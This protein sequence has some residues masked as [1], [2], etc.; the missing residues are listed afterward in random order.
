MKTITIGNLPSKPYMHPADIFKY[1]A[2][3]MNFNEVNFEVQSNGTVSYKFT[4][5]DINVPKEFV[6]SLKIISKNSNT[7][8]ANYRVSQLSVSYIVSKTGNE[9]LVMQERVF[10]RCV[11][12][13][14]DKVTI[15]HINLNNK[16]TIKGAPTFHIYDKGIVWNYTVKK[17][18]RKPKGFPCSK[19][20]RAHV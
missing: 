16:T 8:Y 15:D 19:I 10:H 13:N 18:S 14:N 11:T 17:D 6:E 5:G 4:V 7:S 3:N 20:G 1:M 9:V 2:E 12:V